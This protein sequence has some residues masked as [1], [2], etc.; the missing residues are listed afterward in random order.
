MNPFSRN[1][2][3]DGITKGRAYFLSQSYNPINPTNPSSE[4]PGA[5]P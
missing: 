2:R 1:R 4:M 3:K 5:F